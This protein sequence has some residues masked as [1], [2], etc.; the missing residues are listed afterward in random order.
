MRKITGFEKKI[1]NILRKWLNVEKKVKNL[2][3]FTNLKKL[4]FKFQFST[5]WKNW[6]LSV[7]NPSYEILLV[8][9]SILDLLFYRLLIDIR[10]R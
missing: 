5:Q 9:F 1:D 8:Y 2:K 3:I 10:K 6:N 7:N 4:L